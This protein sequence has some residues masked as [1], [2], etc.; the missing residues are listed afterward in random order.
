MPKLARGPLFAKT[1]VGQ[2]TSEN[3]VI[4]RKSNFREDPGLLQNSLGARCDPSSGTE[5]TDFGAFGARFVVAVSPM[6]TFSTG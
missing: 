5:R 1:A 4:K 6:P 2:A 3:A